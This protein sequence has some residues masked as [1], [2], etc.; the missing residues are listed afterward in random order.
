MLEKTVGM[1][2]EPVRRA[3]TPG[4]RAI[5]WAI[6]L[7]SLLA[8]LWAAST[9]LHGARFYDERFSMQN[10]EAALATGSVRPANGWYPRLSWL[11]HTAVAAA[12]GTL[13]RLTG[14]ESLAVLDSEGRAT[15][16]TY[17]L[18]RLV[19]VACGLAALWL[20]WRLGRRLFPPAVA[21]GGLFLMAVTPWQIRASLEFKP[22]A[23]L[24][25]MTLLAMHWTLDTA[26][27][28]TAGGY[29]RAGLGVGLALS[30]KLNGGVVALPLVLLT[31][32]RRRLRHWLWLVLAGTT[33]LLIF[34]ALNTP[35]E[36]Y[37]SY[38]RRIHRFYSRYEESGFWEILSDEVA[39]LVSGQFHGPLVG[40]LALAG[41]LALLW[42]VARRRPDPETALARLLFVVFPIAY[43][44]VLAAG[45]GRAKNNNLVQLVP[46]TSIAAAWLVWRGW[47]WLV[48]R[49]PG[50][51]RPAA[52]LPLLAAAAAL[53]ALPGLSFTWR[54]GSVSTVELAS[55]R[56]SRG[57]PGLPRPLVAHE[58][59]PRPLDLSGL[60]DRTV[61]MEVESLADV[62]RRVLERTDA[63]VFPLKRLRGRGLQPYLD[64]LVQTEPK[65]S[66]VSVIDPPWHRARGP[67]LVVLVHPWQVLGEPLGFRLALRPEAA[68]QGRV[69]RGPLPSAVQPGE[70]VS[71]EIEPPAGVML[72][73]VRLSGRTMRLFPT[74][75]GDALVSERLPV[76]RRRAPLRVE[77]AAA[78]ATEGPL[79]LTVRRWLDRSP[80]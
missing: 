61:T 25:M 7:A 67:S 73:E 50:L 20:A 33:A 52:R 39:L 16:T 56:L 43:A 18:C 70:L 54:S 79:R 66:A 42:R 69:Y 5:V 6:L 40:G 49:R 55:Q 47:R 19:S 28:P 34:V 9:G 59:L 45:S 74:R 2:D 1:S 14:L 46:F 32:L 8:Y 62:S 48:D 58:P 41:L 13:G 22:D 36:Y 35:V 11:P 30:S 12:A 26:R 24:L 68:P 17:L 23:L 4:E 29:A 63:E 65:V 71:I 75:S 10:V 37:W 38:F 57:L 80:S 78:A 31:A 3:A 21:L 27:A 44:L 53:A 64:R 76:G 15:A 60:P 77:L 72:A 51:A